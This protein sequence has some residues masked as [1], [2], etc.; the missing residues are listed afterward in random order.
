MPGGRFIPAFVGLHPVSLKTCW[1][2]EASI[3]QCPCEAIFEHGFVLISRVF[4]LF[5]VYCGVMVVGNGTGSG[6]GPE[7][8]KRS[9]FGRMESCYT[10]PIA[11]LGTKQR[12]CTKEGPQRL[13][14]GVARCET[15][16][17]TQFH[18]RLGRQQTDLWF[19]AIL[20]S[21]VTREQ[22]Q[23]VQKKTLT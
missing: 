3:D 9:F 2:W 17:C 18:F 10:F 22:F 19:E 14:V 4:P 23:K 13:P 11:S 16:K 12:M 21:C 1:G 7:S 15:P 8:E 6:V 20:G 5:I